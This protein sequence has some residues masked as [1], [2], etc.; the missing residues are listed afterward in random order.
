MPWWPFSLGGA[1]MGDT[2][3]PALSPPKSNPSSAPTAAPSS[4]TTTAKHVQGP[5]G[6]TDPDAPEGAEA[7]T[8]LA[9][10]A[11]LLEPF[12]AGGGALPEK[13]RTDV[14]QKLARPNAHLWE[15]VPFF[16]KQGTSL[17][18][19]FVQHH[20]YGPPKPSWGVELTLFTT[21]LREVSTYSHLSSLARL[22]SALE[23]SSL[24]PTPKD[25][26]V[27]PI[28]FKVKR[29]NL[30]GL[31]ADS[32]AQ[33]TG[34]REI[35]GEWVTNKRLWRRM[36]RE[37]T[38]DKPA[39]AGAGGNK[40][41][42][43]CLYLHGG[44]YYM[45]SAETHRYLTISVSRYCDARVFAINYR[46]APETRFPGQLHDAVSAY[47]RLTV[48]LKIPPENIIIAG[49]SAGGGLA[50]ATLMYL[51]DE[52]YPLPSGGVLMSPWVDLTMSC[53][54][55]TTNRPYD[56]LPTP[57][58]EDDH[59]HPVK[60][61]LG[62][63]IDK[64]LTHPYVSPLFGK[65]EGLPPLLIQ[66][67]DAEVLRDEITLLAHKAAI[68]GVKVEHEIFEDCVHVFQA[69]LFLEASRK[70]F[71]SQRSFVKH[72][73]PRL[74]RKA[75]ERAAAASSTSA[76]S[77]PGSASTAAA[78]SNAPSPD[79]R[80]ESSATGGSA[81]SGFDFAEVDRSI[82]ADAH[83]VDQQGN[84]DKKSLRSPPSA[85]GLDLPSGSSE[86]DDVDRLDDEMDEDDDDALGVT[87]VDM[88]TDSS[89][90]AASP[91]L[92]GK[93]RAVHSPADERATADALVNVQAP[94][95]DPSSSTLFAAPST[96]TSSS[97]NSATATRT[98]TSA[99]A[100]EGSSPT[101]LAS[102]SLVDA[103]PSVR[104][105]LRAYA[106]A[107]DLS[108]S[109]LRKTT[110]CRRPRPLGAACRSRR[111]PRPRSR[112]RPQRRRPRRRRASAARRPSRRRG[113][114]RPRRRAAAAA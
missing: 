15:Y 72:T 89:D 57:N 58:D 102:P 36:T 97:S 44:A 11:A 10:W 52:G 86:E 21:F 64:Y 63:Q 79:E 50:L 75:A 43:V 78:T 110:R 85:G 39:E 114:L 111:P 51:R 45:F 32:D 70:A 20:I 71:Q 48:D 81:S 66:A 13:A 107:R 23:L 56:Y 74:K 9:S 99:G 93:R 92:R 46:L 55:W 49:D 100:S 3:S 26:I 18:K 59:M 14:R 7:Q 105:I 6:A 76:S 96:S 82:A 68:A 35:A 104:P 94:S 80:D 84:A 103:H 12:N 62:D 38:L 53:E 69:F 87:D 25:G 29:R 83:E 88:A 101:A 19:A 98:S 91:V 37:W 60:C 17:T 113:R 77:A 24:L 47:M 109:T 34:N 8:A 1:S 42:L 33:E 16:A 95:P 61:L 31:L 108:M 112:P 28:S 40:D 54:S 67:G 30:R 22:R 65:F 90:A 106:S 4:P 2:S 41:G 5:G 73:L 27:T